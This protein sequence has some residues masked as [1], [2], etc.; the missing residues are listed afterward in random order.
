MLQLESFVVS[1]AEFFLICRE[2]EPNFD[3]NR[4][5]YVI[6]KYH[7]AGGKRSTHPIYQTHAG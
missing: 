7:I 4:K 2:N 3:N 1:V 6:P 5:K